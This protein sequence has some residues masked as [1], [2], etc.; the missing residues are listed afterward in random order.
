M[1]AFAGETAMLAIVGAVTVRVLVA[2]CPPVVAVI[3]VVPAAT[4]VTTPAPLTEAVAGLL[5]DHVTVEAQLEFVLF[6]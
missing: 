1:E 6:E 3:T 5:L 2:D 4:P